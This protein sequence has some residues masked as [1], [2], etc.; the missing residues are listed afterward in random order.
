MNKTS[1]SFFYMVLTGLLMFTSLSFAQNGSLTLNEDPE[2][3]Q[4]IELKKAINKEESD[5]NN[6]K[7]QIYSGS[8]SNAESTKSKFNSSVG[9]WSS[10]LVYE[11]PNYKVWVGS[12]RSRLEADRA[13][14]EIHKKFPSAFIFKPKKEKE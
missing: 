12:F 13:L 14:I 6:Y 7:I 10:Q 2:L 1:P 5:S 4:V 11:T 3:S 8:L 9:K